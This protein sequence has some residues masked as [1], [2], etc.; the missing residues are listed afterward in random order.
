MRIWDAASGR[1][2]H[3]IPCGG[4]CV[5]ALAFS[6][7]GRHL[8]AGTNARPDY[9][10]IWN[11]DTGELE[12]RLPGHR[13]AVLSLVY[14]ADGSELLSG[15]YD[16]TA[17]IWDVASGAELRRASRPRMVGLGGGLFTRRAAAS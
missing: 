3:E 9:I 5:F 7:D 4:D 2:L 13:D 10:K 6:P 8:A 14:S 16:N 17:R 1:K 15:S 12:K 11:A